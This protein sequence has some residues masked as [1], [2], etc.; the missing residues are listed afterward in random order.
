M[1]P[2]KV[3]S[4][5]EKIKIIEYATRENCGVRK[6]AKHFKI[7][8]TCAA[9]IIKNKDNILNNFQNG[10]Y[11]VRRKF[12]GPGLGTT[13]DKVVFEWFQRVRAQKIPVSG[14]MLQEKALEVSKELGEIDFKASNGWLEKFRNRHS[15]SF[16]AISG[17]A[18]AVNVNVVNEWIQHLPNLLS[19]YLPENVF[20]ADETG[21]LFRALPDKTLCLKNE[22]CSGGKVAKERLT[23]LLC[24]SMTGEKLMPL[25]IGKAARPRCFKGLDIDKFPVEWASNSKSWM[26]RDIMNSWLEKL[27]RLMQ[28]K[29]RKIVLFIDNAACHQRLTLQNIELVFFP[30]N[31]TATSQ[32]LDQGII[33]NFK[34]KYR[35]LVLMHLISN[36]SE[37]TTQQDLVKKIDVLQAVG[38]IDKAWKAVTESTVVNCFR[39]ASFCKDPIHCE[40]TEAVQVHE[41]FTQF[42]SQFNS[43][44]LQEYPEIDSSLAIED[45]STQVRCRYVIMLL[46]SCSM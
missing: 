39:K 10:N 8:K 23:I 1:A 34:H 16:K 24:A 13:I 30:P 38:W 25:V 44:N 45:T 7:G 36:I 3:L 5:S 43:C 6:I 26:T 18:G 22:T 19:A 29:N 15:I 37:T 27:D 28:R 42:E 20:N 33:K 11:N 2:R 17:E 40:P 4:R 14:P 21:L 46:Y 35:K 9:E 41:D 32:P 31:V 12:V